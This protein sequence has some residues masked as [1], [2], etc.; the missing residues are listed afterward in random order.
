MGVKVPENLFG[1]EV[2]MRN[3]RLPFPGMLREPHGLTSQKTAFFT[4]TTVK[5]SN[6]I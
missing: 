4:V 5:T 3:R 6:L 2:D 1:P